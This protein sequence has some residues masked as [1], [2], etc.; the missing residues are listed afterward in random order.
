MRFAIAQCH[1]CEQISNLSCGKIPWKIFTKDLFTQ[2]RREKKKSKSKPTSGCFLCVCARTQWSCAWRRREA[3]V[4]MRKTFNALRLLILS[5]NYRNTFGWLENVLN[6]SFLKQFV[7]SL[8]QTVN[9]QIHWY[10][11]KV[12]TNFNNALYE[13]RKKRKSLSTSAPNPQN[14]FFDSSLKKERKTQFLYKQ[15][16]VLESIL[17]LKISSTIFFVTSFL[18]IFIL[19]ATRNIIYCYFFLWPIN[20]TT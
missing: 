6:L 17:C 16:A 7:L 2:W 5:A 11:Q 14:F 10:E 19:W 18:F 13:S 4:S 3:S 12:E 20:P 9:C 15:I 1:F 8:A